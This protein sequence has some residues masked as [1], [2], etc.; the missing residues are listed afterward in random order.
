MPRDR[1]SRKRRS[2]LRERLA[3][4]NAERENGVGGGNQRLIIIVA[5]IGFILIAGYL[6]WKSRAPKGPWDVNKATAAQ[7]ETLPGI[8]PATAKDIIS[9]RPYNTPADL[10]KVKGIGEKTVEKIKGGLVFPET[11]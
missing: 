8:G 5:I 7:L 11:E 9:G 6:F 4:H 2:T 10:I 3:R 1:E